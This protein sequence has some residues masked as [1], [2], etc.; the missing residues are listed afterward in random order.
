MDNS[1]YIY[2]EKVYHKDI[3]DYWMN[4][5]CRE[6]PLSADALPPATSFSV[7]A[8]EKVNVQIICVR[9]SVVPETIVD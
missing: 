4:K 9:G 6:S 7:F 2:A 5:K 1:V 3:R 8:N